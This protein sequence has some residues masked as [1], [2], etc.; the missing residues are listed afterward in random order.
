MKS[1]ENPPVEDAISKL[2]DGWLKDPGNIKK[3]F[4]ELK[5][6]ISEKTGVELVFKSRPGVSYSLRGHVIKSTE[7]EK[8]GTFFVMVDVIDDDPDNRWLSVCF[9]EEAITDPD[10]R[11]DMV[12][13][14][15]FGR[16]GHCFDIYEYEESDLTY[17][18]QRIDEACQHTV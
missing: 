17:L 9:Y 6:K 1:E 12:P 5:G 11:G 8:E 3:M 15:L 2:V 4:L 14:G 7:M 13:G 16:D 10:E 18:V